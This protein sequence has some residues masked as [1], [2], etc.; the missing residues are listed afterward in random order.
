MTSANTT[1][2]LAFALLTL[3]P[4][5]HAAEAQYESRFI[6]DPEV[7]NRGHVHA[8]A[9]VECPNGDLRAVWYENGSKLPTPPYY[10][11]RQDKSSDVR[12]AGS[13][14]GA[15]AKDWDTPFVTSD[16]FGVSDN[17]PTMA[18]DRQGRLWLFH[19]TMLGTPE[20]TWGSS[21]LQYRISS[22][23]DRAGA[24]VWNDGGLL[25][26]HPQGIEAVVDRMAERLDTPE[27]KKQK[28][29]STERAKAFVAQ[30]KRWSKDPMHRRLGWMPRAHPLVRADGTLVVPL[31][32]ENFNIPMMAM[33]SDGGATWTYSN[34]V[35]AAGLTQPTLVEFAD[36]EIVAFFR[37]S[38]PRRR[39]QRASSVDGGVTW[40]VPKLT[41]RLHPGGGI[42]AI[43]LKSGHLALVYNNKETKPRDKLAISLST[44]RGRTWSWTRQLE[45]T[46]GGRFDY[47]SVIQTR[48]GKIH[49]TYSYHLR[50]IKHVEFSE[51]WIREA[52]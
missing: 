42:D 1:R 40:S 29:F 22:D 32:N 26:P 38:D 47:P 50:T 25:L 14:R 27:Q 17:N 44:D 36:G 35:P 43:I 11:E 52:D 30:L 3:I 48:D 19:S 6:F 45:D 5:I 31:S 46:A 34:P 23:F 21:I 9:L 18:V 10:N 4:R 33:T 12:I 16:T 41:D 20:W 37:N 8:S 7:T 15:G 51:A 2:L 39:V 24:P 49:V 13:R 28:G